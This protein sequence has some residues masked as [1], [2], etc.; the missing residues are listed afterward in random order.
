MPDTTKP[1]GILRRTI[2]H[3]TIQLD[4]LALNDIRLNNKLNNKLDM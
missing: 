3:N 2:Q 4:A 1:E